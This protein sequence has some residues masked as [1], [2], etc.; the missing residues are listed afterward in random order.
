MEAVESYAALSSFLFDT[1]G[2]TW[3]DSPGILASTPYFVRMARAPIEVLRRDFNELEPS[4][5]PSFLEVCFLLRGEADTQE[6]AGTLSLP[7][8]KRLGKYL[9][10]EKL[11]QTVPLYPVIVG[12][13]TVLKSERLDDDI[14]P[15]TLTSLEEKI[16]RGETSALWLKCT[17]WELDR[18]RAGEWEPTEFDWSNF[19]IGR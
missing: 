10:S 4:E 1:N 9:S 7:N 8:L 6:V 3:D 16:S 5:K 15:G 11:E 13:N 17:Y 12:G 14:I 2:V 18:Y 19:T